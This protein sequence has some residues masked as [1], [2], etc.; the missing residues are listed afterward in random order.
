MLYVAAENEAA[1]FVE[2]LYGT[3]AGKTVMKSFTNKEQPED[4]TVSQSSLQK[5]LTNYLENISTR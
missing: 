4:E 2:N 3:K 5:G 1:E